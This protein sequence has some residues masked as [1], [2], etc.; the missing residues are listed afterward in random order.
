MTETAASETSVRVDPVRIDT[1]ADIVC[2]WCYVGEA[3]L[4]AAAEQGDA[5]VELVVHAFELDPSQSEP[6]QVLDMLSRKYGVPLEQAQAMEERVAGLARAEGLPYTTERVTSN[7]FDAHRLIAAAAEQGLG[8]AV[9]EAI[10]RGHFAG[11]VDISSHASLIDA[12]A[13]A[14]L[15]R[16]L[17]ARVLEGEDYAA[18]VLADEAQARELGATGVP[19]TVVGGR[20]AIPGAVETDQYAQV[21]ARVAAGE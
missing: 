2:P 1:W 10:Q 21:I 15:D 11:E 20:L 14:G 16:D 13:S 4:R 9:R 6:E 17:A 18:A 12:A 19:F 3:R 7:T 8:L 5:P